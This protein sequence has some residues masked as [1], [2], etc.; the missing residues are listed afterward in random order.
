MRTRILLCI[1]FVSTIGIAQT[2]LTPAEELVASVD[3]DVTLSSEQIA[4]LTVA[5]EQYVQAAQIAN[6][7]FAS[8]DTS[9][10]QTKATAW[11]VYQEQLQAILTAEQYQ[12]LQHKRTDRRNALLNRINQLKEKRQ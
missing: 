6:Q 7:Q 12:I 4:Q 11:Q 1:L 3:S 9:L 10:V 8:D 5:A 2:A